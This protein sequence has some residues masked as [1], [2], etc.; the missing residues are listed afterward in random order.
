MTSL[1]SGRGCESSTDPS[2]CNRYSACEGDKSPPPW[3]G[4]NCHQEGQ[5]QRTGRCEHKGGWEG[6][7]SQ[8]SGPQTGI[9]WPKQVETRIV[10]EIDKG[11]PMLYSVRWEGV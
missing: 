4:Q 2:G 3:T 9:L 8:I 5:P 6:L 11:L 1:K 10:G 7:V